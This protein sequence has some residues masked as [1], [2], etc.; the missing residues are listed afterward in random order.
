MNQ[1]NIRGI[2]YSV[3]NRMKR[4]STQDYEYLEQIAFEGYRSFQINNLNVVDVVYK[5]VNDEGYFDVPNGY[6]NYTKIGF[7]SKGKIVNLGLNRHIALPEG[8]PFCETPPHLIDTENSTE[9]LQIPYVSHYYNGQAHTA[10]YGIGGGYAEAYY[11]ED[12]KNRRIFI[13]GKV[14]GNQIVMEYIGTGDLCGST[15][16]NPHY[17]EALRTWILWQD[18][19]NDK[20]VSMGEKQR[21]QQQYREAIE[22]AHFSDRPVT[23]QEIL[24]AIFMGYSQ[25]VK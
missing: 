15:Y 13:D 11:R 12:R 9:A 10:T 3:L 16:V 4:T 23:A 8:L 6:I 1:Y 2:V 7:V 18:I 21:K 20:S 19:E 5:T 17:E 22:N 25:S 14:P 24:D